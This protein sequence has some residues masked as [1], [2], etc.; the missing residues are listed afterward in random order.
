VTWLWFLA[1]MWVGCAVGVFVAGLAFAAA[2]DRLDSGERRD[3][4]LGSPPDL[5]VIDGE[6]DR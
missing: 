2:R 5:R 4:P 3:Q 6:G 1:G